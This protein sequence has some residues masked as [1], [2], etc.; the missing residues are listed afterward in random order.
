MNIRALPILYGGASRLLRAAVLI[1]LLPLL[2]SEAALAQFSQDGMKLVGTLAVGKAWQGHSIALSADGN[3]AIV[4]GPTDNAQLGAAWVYTRANNGVWTQQSGK[5]VGTGAVGVAGQGASVALSAD[6]A[7]AIVGGPG[8]NGDAGA[9]W[10]FTRANNGVWTQQGGK[11]VGEG[12]VG[13]V[14]WQGTSVALSANGATA[15][16]GGPYDTPT[17]VVN[18]ISGIG[19]AWVFTQNG[20]VWTQQ[21]K[22]VGAGFVGA[23]VLQGNSVALSA[24]GATAVVGGPGDNGNDYGDSSIGAT[25]VFTRSGGA[26]TQQGGKLVGAGAVGKAWQGWSVALSADGGT[27][28]E[29]GWDDNSGAGAAWVFTR[30]GA[31][32]TQQGR[33]LVGAGAVNGAFGA[34]QGNSVALSGNGDTAIVGGPDDK[35]G[36]GATWVY[37]REGV[38]WTQQGG[39]LVGTGVVGPHGAEQGCSVAISSDGATAI[40][41][42]YYDN[43]GAGAAWLFVHGGVRPLTETR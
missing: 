7:T 9:A 12:A 26:W 13:G 10:V 19:A 22:L 3:T 32:W 37:T 40:V 39:K 38:V 28:I 21:A 5:L 33:K 15:I 27:A 1:W 31:A 35:S 23:I 18:C 36:V 42:G 25:W 41:G 16:V 43:S 4:G 11:L 8:D 20:G 34:F 24:D 6:G 17:C 29:G 14:A 2:S 30:G